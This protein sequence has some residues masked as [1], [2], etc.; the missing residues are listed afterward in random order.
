MF[1]SKKFEYTKADG[2]VSERRAVILHFDEDSGQYLTIDVSKVSPETE[3]ALLEALNELDDEFRRARNELI[4]E[5]GLG[6]R[7]R[8]FKAK[9]IEWL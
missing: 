3:E 8:N 5:M 6:D 2:S 7:F 4:A 1:R 9:G